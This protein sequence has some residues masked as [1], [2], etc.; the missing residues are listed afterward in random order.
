M[1]YEL[2]GSHIKVEEIQSISTPYL[3]KESY[4][5]K[6]TVVFHVMYKGAFAPQ[7]YSIPLI[8]GEIKMSDVSSDYIAMIDGTTLWIDS[9]GQ[10]KENSYNVKV[11]AG[12]VV[13]ERVMPVFTKLIELIN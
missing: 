4:Y 8:E 6:T 2:F 13:G 5:N 3:Y 12:T 9:N 1:I 11:L 7:R 10:P